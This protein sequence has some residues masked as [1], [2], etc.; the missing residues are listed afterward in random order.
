[1]CMNRLSPWYYG[2]YKPE[3]Q[4]ILSIETAMT[5]TPSGVGSDFCAR[6]FLLAV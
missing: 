4:P 6:K 2:G 5:E 1:M 3:P